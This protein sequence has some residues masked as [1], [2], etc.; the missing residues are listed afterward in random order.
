MALVSDSLVVLPTYNERDNL[1]SLVDQLLALPAGL[2][3]IVVDDASPD[4]TG[5]VADRLARRQP[6][7]VSVIHRPGKLGL[8]TAYLAGFA[9][10]LER[11]AQRILT[12]DADFSHQPRY[13]PQLIRS[14]DDGH[15]LAIGS[16][17]VDGGGMPGCPRRRRLLSA[18][19]NVFAHLLLDL[20]AR[21][22]T[23]GFRCYRR[24]VLEGLPLHEIRSDG[25]SFLVEILFLVKCQ[26]FRVAEVPI[27]F[28]DRKR[29]KSKISR[30]EI[31]KAIWTV[32]RLARRR[33]GPLPGSSARRP[34]V[35]ER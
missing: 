27:L 14:C 33:L 9:L 28:E 34:G 23:A 25:Y 35:E 6:Q 21:D 29:G 2:G 13:V 32:L 5:A 30:Q 11:G 8:G 26:G 10:A 16:R 12:M 4:G 18:A 17:Y 1:R 15:D 31:W 20:S 7:R 3:V 19:A 24:E 22:A